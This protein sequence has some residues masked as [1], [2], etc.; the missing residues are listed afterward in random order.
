MKTYVDI[1]PAIVSFFLIT[2]V[3]NAADI[4][5]DKQCQAVIKDT[6]EAI[7]DNPSLGD[8]FQPILEQIM[9]L[10]KKRCAD[11]EYSNAGELLELA[12]GMVGT[13]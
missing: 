13:E 1:I 4:M 12:R 10:A 8:K 5:N 2:G 6:Q 7:A 11:K 3:A 9:E